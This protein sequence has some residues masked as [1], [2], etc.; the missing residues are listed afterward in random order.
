MKIRYVVNA[1]IPTSRAHGLQ[2]MK[3]CEALTRAGVEVE[4]VVPRRHNKITTD[5]FAYYGLTERFTITYLPTIDLVPYRVPFAFS[6][7]TLAFTY[8]L[9]RYLKHHKDDVCLY[10]R[11]EEGWLLPRISRATFI[12]EN[13]IRLAKRHAEERALTRSQGVVVVTEHYKDYLEKEYGYASARILVAADGVDLA[14]FAR[15]P[16]KEEARKRLMLSETKKLAVYVGSDLPWKGLGVLKE[17]ARLLPPEFD[18]IFVGAIT[19]LESGRYMGERPHS[20]VPL[21]LAAAD[22][23]VLTGEAAS[24]TAMHYTS[25]LKL[26]EYMAARRPIVVT[27]L[28][29]FREILSEQTATFVPAGDAQA[30][31]AGIVRAATDLA[32]AIRAEDAYSHVQKYSWDERAKRILAFVQTNSREN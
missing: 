19:P 7:Q 24:E 32:S 30:L 22:V 11:G 16:T 31:A 25:P 29:S 8:S 23:L 13:H 10:V 21:W 9:A 26:F 20:E 6:L 17:A 27:D 3:T 1:R 15:A 5:P 4:L 18:V 2:V 14:E 12:W 28:P